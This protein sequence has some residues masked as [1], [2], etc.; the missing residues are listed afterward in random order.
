MRFLI[1]WAVC[2]VLIQAS[3]SNN[4][5]ANPTVEK[6]S[7]FTDLV[8]RL[9]ALPKGF[10]GSQPSEIGSRAPSDADLDKN[11]PRLKEGPSPK[12]NSFRK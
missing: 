2:T 5:Q 7:T 4:S 1:N 12:A 9:S 3:A 8:A 6:Y 11:C 10:A